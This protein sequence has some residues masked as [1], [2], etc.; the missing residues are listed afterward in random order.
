MR[1]DRVHTQPELVAGGLFQQ[2]RIHPAPFDRFE[3]LAP[4]CLGHG[5][6]IAQRTVDIQ[7]ETGHLLAIG[8]WELQLAFQHPRVGIEEL[9]LDA[10]LAHPRHDV[11]V[12]AHLAQLHRHLGSGH[13]QHRCLRRRHRRGGQAR[14]R[15]ADLHSQP[16]HAQHADPTKCA[17]HVTLP[18]R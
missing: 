17:F 15:H 14:L 6:C 10:G 2:A 5:H 18:I 4:L 8:E 1:R 11:G 16:Q 12:Q 7:R 13:L 3:D 9:H